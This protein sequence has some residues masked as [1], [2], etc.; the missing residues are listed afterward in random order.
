MAKV[1]SPF[2]N[3]C[4]LT[5][6]GVVVIIINS[7]IITKYGRRRVFLMTGMAACGVCQLIVAV[8]YTT[9]PG[10]LATGKVN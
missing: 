2:M 5:A 10:T 4:I 1:G 7:C 6:V 3:A 9:H 8:I